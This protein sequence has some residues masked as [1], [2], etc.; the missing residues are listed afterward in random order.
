MQETP[1]KDLGISDDIQASLRNMNFEKP[2]PVQEPVYY[3]HLFPPLLALLSTPAP[4]QHDQHRG[5][6]RRACNDGNDNPQ[7]HIFRIPCLRPASLLCPI[8]LLCSAPAI[9]RSA[10]VRLFLVCKYIFGAMFE[11]KRRIS[12]AVRAL[13]ADIIISC[14]IEVIQVCFF[15]CSKRRHGKHR[16]R[17]FSGERPA[18]P[19][20]QEQQLCS[21]RKYRC[22]FRRLAG[23]VGKRKA[24]V[25]CRRNVSPVEYEPRNHLARIIQNCKND[26]LILPLDLLKDLFGNDCSFLRRNQQCLDVYKRQLHILPSFQFHRIFY[27]FSIIP[28]VDSKSSLLQK[29]YYF[30][31]IDW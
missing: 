16:Y 22:I 1:F 20:V 31:Y 12:G 11:G 23:C 29:I 9:R 18:V 2:T 10:A 24:H 21:L 4:Q 19:E 26:C 17:C 7:R 28:E 13:R 25:H 3:T 27:H 6:H 8:F 15:A 30:V 14:S 5:S